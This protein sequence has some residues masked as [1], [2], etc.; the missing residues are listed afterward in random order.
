M[1]ARISILFVGTLLPIVFAGGCKT[2]DESA[3]VSMPSLTGD[4]PGA[5]ALDTI[6]TSRESVGD[7]SVALA[8][9]QKTPR[10]AIRTLKEGE[11]LG[12]LVDGSPGVVLLDFYADWCAPCRKQSSELHELE[13]YALEVNAQII[14][15]NVEEHRALAKEYKVSSLPTL[16]TVKDGAVQER[17]QGFTKR[18]QVKAMLR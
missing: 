16:L 12:G 14:K 18:D 8:S 11:D 6:T 1:S 13:D 7:D 2:F 3:L 5:D 17:K 9:S 10:Q 4:Q 15:V